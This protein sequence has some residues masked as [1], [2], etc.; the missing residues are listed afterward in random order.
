L[1]M[2]SWLD[3]VM[4]RAGET[5]QLEDPSI[6][7]RVM[8]LDAQVEAGGLMAWR[9]VDRLS[10]GQFDAVGSA[11]SKWYNTELARGISRLALDVDGLG[12]TLSRADPDAPAGGGAEAAYRECPGLTLSAGTSEIMLYAIASAHLRVHEDAH[13]AN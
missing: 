12:G 2:R 10:R 3:A 5:G 6:A 9:L 13:R 11:M 4:A 8:A 1:K 7:E